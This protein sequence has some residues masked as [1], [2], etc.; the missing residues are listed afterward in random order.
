VHLL[1]QQISSSVTMLGGDGTTIT[2][3]VPILESTMSGS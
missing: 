1:A 2:L 3:S